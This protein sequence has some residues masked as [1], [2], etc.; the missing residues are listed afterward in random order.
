MAAPT[1]RTAHEATAWLAE[2]GYTPTT[3]TADDGAV[4]V[5]EHF[6]CGRCGGSGHLGRGVVNVPWGVCFRCGNGPKREGIRKTPII[7]YARKAKSAMARRDKAAAVRVAETAAREVKMLDGQR[8]WCEANGYGRVT[9]AER[10]AA[11]E[12][13]K[14]AVDAAKTHVGTV[15]ERAV[16][17]ATVKAIPSWDGNYGTTYLVVMEDAAGNSMVWKTGSPGNAMEKGATVTFKA[18]VTKHGHYNGVAQTTVSRVKPVETAAME[19]EAA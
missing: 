9:F 7:E 16:F 8:N 13:A 18:T 5:V 12:A 3:E 1:I 11:R 15:G 17:T 14:A 6:A 2:H 4:M 10:D 19:S